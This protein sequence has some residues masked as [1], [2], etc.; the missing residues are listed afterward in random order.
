MYFCQMRLLV[1]GLNKFANIF[2][3]S[4]F[5]IDSEVGNSENIIIEYALPKI[6]L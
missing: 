5:C 3:Y 6:N 2:V 1:V 4:R